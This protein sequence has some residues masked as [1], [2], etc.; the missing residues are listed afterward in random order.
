[1]PFDDP[2]DAGQAIRR[3]GLVAG[4]LALSALTACAPRAAPAT[5][6]IGFQKSGVLLLAKCRGGLEAALKAQGPVTAQWAQ[7]VAGPP[8]IEALRAGAIDLGAVGDTPP[9]LAQA[10]GADFVYAAALPNADAAEAVIAPESSPIRTVADLKGARV[11]FT[12]GS[13][14][15]LL[16]IEALKTAGL[17]LADIQPVYLT[18]PDGAGAFAK[19]AI[20]AWAVW[21]PFLAL[22]QARGGVRVV[23]DRR[24]LSHSSSF[25]LAWR[26]F[27]QRQPRLLAAALDFL[28]SVAAWGV[29][30]PDA[31]AAIIA[32]QTGLAPAIAL[33]VLR[34][35]P[36]AIQPVT[37]PILARQQQAADLL[38][39][40]GFIPKPIAVAAAVWG[41]WK[42]SPTPL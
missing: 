2:P 14:S 26:P 21:D 7:F 34:R 39:E 5:I 17:T 13:S 30:R 31:A 10:A 15:H 8:L 9:I 37:P 35:A 18:P 36:L 4:A 20:D 1:M 32:Q 40:A 19:G 27:A 24:S 6:R 25:I 23:V 12:R 38:N 42:P 33:T 22:A 28:A 3:R 16:V 11:G 41:G 29:A